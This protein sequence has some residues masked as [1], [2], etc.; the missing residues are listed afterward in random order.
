MGQLAEI[1]RYRAIIYMYRANIKNIPVLLYIHTLGNTG[2]EVLKYPPRGA[3]RPEGVN[4]LVGRLIHT[5]RG[6]AYILVYEPGSV[7]YDYGFGEL[8]VENVCL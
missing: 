5:K 7:E 8:A 2:I 3:C 6:L 1:P 4:P